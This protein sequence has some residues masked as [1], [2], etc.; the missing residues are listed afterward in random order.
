MSV[1][2]SESEVKNARGWLYTDFKYEELNHMPIELKSIDLNE[3]TTWEQ[4]EKFIEEKNE[5]LQAI[6]AR[7]KEN[8]IEEFW[9]VVQV[10][11]GVL[12][13]HNISV[14]DIEKGYSKH[15]EKIK[16]RPRKVEV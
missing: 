5:F 3:V 16:N 10:M 4:L 2:I 1:V 11:I 7:D 13:K 14:K 12:Q 9:D 8:S 15:L 6:A